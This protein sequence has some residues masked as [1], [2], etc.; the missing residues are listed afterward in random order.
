MRPPRIAPPIPFHPLLGVVARGRS[1][2]ASRARLVREVERGVDWDRMPELAE[3]HALAPLLRHHLEV[4]S[5]AAPR[6]VQRTLFGLS[7]RHRRR[8]QLWRTLLA[9]MASELDRRGVRALFLKGAALAFTVYPEPELRPMSDIDVL[10]A[11][12][13]LAAAGEVLA[14]LGYAAPEERGWASDLGRH[15]HHLAQRR[16]VVDGIDVPVEVHWQLGIADRR[17]RRSLEVL[18]P[19]RGSV[20]YEGVAASTLGLCDTLVHV[21]YHGF[22]TPLSWP[23]RLYLVSAAD[24]FTIVEAQRDPIG[25]DKLTSQHPQLLRSLAWLSLLSPWEPHVSAR[26]P[27]RPPPDE[28]ARADDYRGWPRERIGERLEDLPRFARD[29]IDPPPL[30]LAIRTGARPGRWGR[31]VSWLKHVRELG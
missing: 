21:H 5:I 7:L 28:L 31:W 9:E 18:W 2:E 19:D 25:W 24:L 26:L 10:V 23:D 29:T 30:W 3:R 27:F 11:K 16:R 1:T 20:S 4:A 17:A 12:R 13:D 6:D 14:R 8:A 15:M 22:R